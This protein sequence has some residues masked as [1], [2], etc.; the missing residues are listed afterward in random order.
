MGMHK[1]CPLVAKDL[2]YVHL[3]VF[4]LKSTQIHFGVLKTSSL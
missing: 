3:E 2:E 4:V 1:Q